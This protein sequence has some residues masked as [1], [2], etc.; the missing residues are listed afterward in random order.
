MK[1]FVKL[2]TIAFALFLFGN[3]AK[4][5]TNQLINSHDLAVELQQDLE[6]L[7]LAT[8]TV[9]ETTEEEP[10]CTIKVSARLAGFGSVE[11]TVSGKCSEIA[12]AVR[13]RFKEAID[14]AKSAIA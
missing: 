14:A 8:L 3:Q 11:F 13:K 7:D 10:T 2:F 4:A 6:A 5:N 1:T 12:G 9:L